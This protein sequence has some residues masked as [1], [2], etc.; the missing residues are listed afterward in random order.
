MQTEQTRADHAAKIADAPIGTFARPENGTEMI[1]VVG[2][3]RDPMVAIEWTLDPSMIGECIMLAIEQSICA[4]AHILY[5]ATRA[6]PTASDVLKS[7][8]SELGTATEKDFRA[9]ILGR[10]LEEF[11]TLALRLETLPESDS[12]EGMTSELRI[13][14]KRENPR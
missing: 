7:I 13:S 8:E 6:S 1:V 2:N 14:P 5:H 12:D 11:P 4:A 9:V 3:D 10:V